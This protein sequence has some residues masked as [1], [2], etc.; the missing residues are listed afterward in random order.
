[1]YVLSEAEESNQA[2][3]NRCI[4]D[5][6]LVHDISEP[7]DAFHDPHRGFQYSV[8]LPGLFS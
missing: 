5:S 3:M 6:V 1:M 8:E 7:G 2:A 4:R